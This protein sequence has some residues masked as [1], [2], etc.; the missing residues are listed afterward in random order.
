[1]PTVGRD[2]PHSGCTR[3]HARPGSGRTSNSPREYNLPVW[4]IVSARLAPW[5]SSTVLGNSL[6]EPGPCGSVLAAARG[7]FGRCGRKVWGL[8]H[9]PE[10]GNPVFGKDHAPARSFSPK[11]FSRKL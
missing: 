1:M 5:T 3:F 9:D 11:S 4:P 8:E 6:A 10:S 2:P 7:T